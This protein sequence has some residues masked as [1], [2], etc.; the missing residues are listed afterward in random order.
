MPIID[1]RYRPSTRESID[2]VMT[3]PVYSEYVKLTD[4]PKR[5]VKSL[6]A[7]I[8][9]LKELG[10]VKAVVAGRDCESSYDTPNTNTSVLECIE[11]APDLFIGFYGFD[12]GKGMPGLRAFRTAVERD[13]M[14]G[15]SIDPCMAHCRVSDARYYPLYAAR[16]DYEI[17]AIITAGLSP[18]MP[19]VILD[20][21]DPRYVDM[22]ARDFPELRILI[23]HGGYPWVNEAVAV[24]MRNRN[25]YLDFSTCESKL[26]GEFYIK[27]ANTCITDKVVFSSANPFVEVAKAVKKYEELELTQEV[28]EKLFYQNGIRFLGLANKL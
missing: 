28:R 7:C 12:P 26:F 10:I 22:V 9:E 18:H 5:P 2:S 21:M 25:V 24:V 16:C 15:A 3:N 13:G 27:A 20:H 8:E 23:S 1:F 14:R 17:P 6:D 4:F 11:K 19:G